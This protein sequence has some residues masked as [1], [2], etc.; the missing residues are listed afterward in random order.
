MMR[1]DQVDR[2]IKKI[3]QRAIRGMQEQRRR[4][5]WRAALAALVAMSAL[6][7]AASASASSSSLPVVSGSVSDSTDLS[8]ATSLAVSGHYAFTTAYSAGRLTAVDISN[9]SKP[10]VAGSTPAVNSLVNSTNV[11]LSGNY[12][13]VVSKNRNATK[14]SGSNDDGTGNSLTIVDVSNP[15]SPTIVGSVHDPV[16]LFGG[17]GVA[18]SGSYA[19]VAA[20]GCVT[21][22]PCPVSTVGNSFAVIDVSNPAAPTVVATLHNSS[23]PAPFTGDNALDHA[24]SVAISG[25]YAYVTAA[26]SNR[27]TVI[28]IAN[29]LSPTIVAS[30]QDATKLNFDVDVATQGHYAYVADQSLEG[31]AVLDISNPANPQIVGTDPS[32]W[33]NG[34]YR[35]RVMGNMAY[36]A[37][38][39]AEAAVMVDIS[40]PAAPRVAGAV[41]DNVRFHST[42]GVAV[43][44]TGRYMLMTSPDLP[45]ESGT[46]YPPFPNQPGGPTATGTVSVLTL[47]PTPVAVSISSSSKPPNPTSQTTANFVF[48][49][50]D[51][52]VSLE[53]QL[54][55][56][57]LS[58]C[59][60][61]SGQSYSALGAGSH[62]FLVQA[63]DAAGNTATSSYTW[64]VTG[65]TGA[66]GNT[67]PPT[68]S[69]RPVQGQTL[70]AAPGTWTGS[71]APTFTYQWEDCDTGGANCSSISNAT[72][73]TYGVAGTDVGS[74]IRVVVKATNSAGSSSAPSSPTAVV[75]AAPQ[76]TAAPKISGS[77]TEDSQLTATTGTWT[78]SPAPTFTYQWERC[79]TGGANCSPISSATASTYV[80]AASDLGST[81]EVVVTASNT[82]GTASATSLPTAVVSAQSAGPVNTGAPTVSGSAVEAQV[83]TASPGTWTGS[84]SPTFAYQWQR[85]D[86]T[87]ANC[88]SIAT[89]P[90]YTIGS[91]DVGSTLQV[92]V[93]GSNSSGSAQASPAAT[94]VVTS[95]PGPL[96]PVLDNFNRADNSGPPGSNWTHM[97]GLSSGAANDL[98]IT[99]DQITG[100]PGTDADYYN[101]QPFGANSEV[102]VT[103]ATKPTTDL[104]SVALSLRYQ[105]PS[106]A[107]SSGYQ[108][109]FIYESGGLDQ[110]RIV[111]RSS[112]ESG[113]VLASA[114]GPELNPGD[115]LLFRAIGTTLE[116]WRGS[117]G[118]WTRILS[119]TNA[120][121]QTAGYLGLAAHN[122][123]V[124]LDDFGGGTLP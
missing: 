55:G 98:F 56:A 95:A 106:L 34:A 41:Y 93:T 72:S 22:N 76:N 79:D 69:G 78:G 88:T 38:D 122:G 2:G 37:A 32:A 89:G 101:V 83:L 26:Y 121:I 65:A 75:T 80:L 114:T 58:P 103:V 118:T 61:S 54:D 44:P 85:C 27:L 102:Y 51:Y 31:L 48:S 57:P 87:G 86:Q 110:Y 40:N 104:D 96:T 28:D 123:A 109:M 35:V 49:T 111:L 120:T 92:V 71:P 112:G 59:Q 62:T 23:L 90:T 91:A 39:Y 117:G 5:L 10:V 9:P 24:T 6:F 3:N 42:T 29:P 36:V 8:G 47:D 20:Q 100:D 18:V 60:S 97:P 25:Q 46:N 63:T 124:R 50:S 107:T 68:I 45:S 53:C 14:G 108:A 12:A 21:G 84:P 105:N 94:A 67:S 115:K 17:Y 7:L 64:V 13:Y 113:S 74:T 30:L 4:F 82:A 1:C 70:T 43:D 33:L 81:V 66:P 73:P 99:S 119:T 116:L 16:N 77:A 19:Y 15:S 11:T 52:V